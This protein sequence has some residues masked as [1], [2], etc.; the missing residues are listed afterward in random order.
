VSS[1]A[2]R[3][4][5]RYLPSAAADAVIGDLVERDVVGIR[6]WRETLVAIWQLRDRTQREVELMS[7]FI[8]D[9]RLALRMLGRAPTFTATAIIT[10]GIA[11]GAATAIFSVANPVIIAP[12]PYRNPD[13]VA[14]V[15]EKS[16]QSER[17]NVGFTTFRDY[18]D[19][20]TSFES[21]A[22][23]GSWEPTLIEG[24]EAERLKGSR[25][26]ASFFRTLG[27]KPAFGRDF[28][29]DEDKPGQ[30]RVLI[31]SHALW[32]RRFGGDS[33]VIGK[34]ISIGGTPMAVVGV[35]PESF[36]DVTAPGVQIWRV[37]GYGVTD[38]YACRTCRH[39]RMIARLKPGVSAERAE[40]ELTRIHGAVKAENP[41]QYASVGAYVVPLQ[42]EVTRA[43]RPAILALGVAVA[44]MLIIAIANVANL[45]LARLVRRDEE[46]AIRTALGA[47]SPRLTRQ[48]LTEALVIAA[49]GGIAGIVVAAVA[50]PALVRQLPTQLPRLGAIHL[51]VTALLVIGVIVLALTVIVG[52]VPR[53]ARGASN[54]ADGLRSGRRL[55]GTRQS[56]VRATLVVMEL[57]FALMLLVGSGLLARS[58]VR[59]LNVDTGFDANNLLTLEINAIDA[60]YDSSRAVWDYHDRVREAVKN[61][62]GV[63]DAAV[64]N[65]LP[66][67]GNQDS[68]GVTAK[69]KPLS[70]PQ[71]APSGDRS[72][73]STNFTDLMKIRVLEGRTFTKAEQLDTANHV[74]MVSKALA[75]KI[76]GG[77]SA[78]GKEIHFG[79]ANRPWYTIVGVVANVR[80][81]GLDATVTQ[82]FYIPERQWFFADNQEVLVVRT[83]GDPNAVAGAV[84]D[85][86]R[87]IDP[88]QPIVKIASMERVIEAST[89]QRRLA[90][91]LFACFAMAAV[92]LAVAGIYG[93]LAGNVAERT[94]EIGLRSALGATPQRILKLIVGQGARLAAVGLM[95]GLFGAYVLTKS[96]QSLLFGVGPHDPTTLIAATLLL[97]VT[98]L[99]ACLVPAL[100]AVRI[101]P[102]QAFR[103]E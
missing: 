91:V 3:L 30:P 86:I 80:H 82:Q 102:S 50:I 57:A 35:M 11:I 92:L 12:L 64:V 99:V 61:I 55:T 75:T 70:N 52:L 13:R 14:V 41:T 44:L 39:L 18:A 66:L 89:A 84:R 53:R 71:D 46:F 45:Q 15:W 56:A 17:D 24:N 40:A 63:V 78:V 16:S 26:S 43:F 59:L 31:L 76:W 7:T 8:S 37:L 10:L 54:V 93:V 34:Q 58:V 9:L 95:V 88:L 33:S 38:P 29:D 72:V 49:L 85:A 96:L 22:A 90:L 20:A 5:E 87:A 36:D 101:D 47:S 94:R 98:T 42:S 73:V 68:Y 27:A 65:Q 28:R 83:K 19:R 21:A 97:L 51:D 100:R 1:L 74:A 69:D 25:V 6:L 103:S 48:L 32:E 23:I 62:P 67:G 81:S 4:I 60:R 2:F 77:E 79:E